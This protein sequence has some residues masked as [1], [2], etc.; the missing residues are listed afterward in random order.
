MTEKEISSCKKCRVCTGCGRGAKRREDLLVVSDFTI[1]GSDGRK[2]SRTEEGCPPPYVLLPN[3]NE[4][5]MLIVVDIGTTT[6]VMQLRRMQDG[7]VLDTFRAVNPQ[8]KYGSDVLS[9]IEAA[10]DGETGAAVEMHQMVKSVIGQGIKQFEG[11]EYV[12]P[13]KGTIKGMVI[14]GNTTMIHLLMGYPVDSLGKAPFTS[15]HLEEIQTEIAGVKTVIMPGISAFVGSDILA[16]IYACEYHMETGKDKND[17][18][19]MF[20]DLGTNGEIVLAEGEKMLATATAAGPAFEGRLDVNVYGADALD[21]LAMLYE[22]GFM[23]ETGLLAEEYFE[24]GV[25]IGSTVVTQADI[26]SLQLAKAAVNAG[27][28]VLLEEAGNRGGS[29]K[30]SEKENRKVYLAGGFGYFLNPRAAVAV[31]L[32]PP[33]LLTEE[34]CELCISIGNA[35]LEGAFCYGRERLGMMP[36]ISEEADRKVVSIKEKIEVYNLANS[37]E[38]EK[39]YIE[40][41]NFPCISKN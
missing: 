25:S 1:P 36:E 29:K 23:D 8:R 24:T 31:G 13:E 17:N 6:I 34:Q 3:V 9:R 39:Y 19:Y 5:A 41:I 14:A 11:L 21:F 10:G 33:E 7:K 30:R 15:E 28:R 12:Q 2:S 26:R 4:N 22:K 32:L 16:G 18:A 27:I 37:P 40:A 38:F 20:I 35:A